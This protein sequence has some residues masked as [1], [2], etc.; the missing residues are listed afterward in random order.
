M[1]VSMIPLSGE[2]KVLDLRNRYLADEVVKL[3]GDWELYWGQIIFPGDLLPP[4]KEIITVPVMWDKD[5]DHPAHGY[6]TYRVS[7]LLPENMPQLAMQ[8][9]FSLNHYQIYIN[10]QLWGANGAIYREPAGSSYSVGPLLRALPGD[11]KLEIIYHVSNFDDLHGGILE[12]PQIG[13]YKKMFKAKERAVIF[14]SFLM[15][16]LFITGM[17][18]ISF[19]M[20]KRDDRSSLF[21]GFFALVMALRTTLYG[22][23]LLLHLF[24]NLSTER[25]AGLGHI[26]LY[27]SRSLFLSFI[28]LSYPFRFSKQL[29][30]AVYGISAAYI[31]LVIFT[32]HSFYI[33]FLLAYQILVLIVGTFS[34]FLLIKKAVGGN[35][36]AIVTLAG[37]IILMGTA[38]N[39]ILYSQELIKTFHMIPLGMAVFI[40]SQ[41][42]L[43]SW[44]I[45]RAFNQ[46]EILAA[47]LLTAN[48]SFRRFVPQE[49]LKF[50]KRERISDVQLGDNV[51]LNMTVLFCDIR[52]FTSLSENMS[53]QENFL[54]LNSFLKRIG[55]VIRE[56]GGFIDKY[57][58]DGIMAL[59]P[60]MPDSAVKAA[61]EMQET[62]K[63][64]NDHRNNSGY[65]NIKI[66]IGINTG[67]LMLGTI[68]EN[69]RMDS[70]VISDAVNLCS[71]IES[72]TKEYGLNIALSEDTYSLLSSKDDLEVRNIGKLTLKGKMKPVTIYEIFNGDQPEMIE[73]KRES[74]EEFEKAV[75]L[76]SMGDYVN[77]LAAF[78][79]LIKIN[80]HDKTLIS[81][82]M[83][84]DRILTDKI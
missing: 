66:G 25:E 36:S 24:N 74:R 4:E 3:E 32:S 33:Q 41:A 16:A 52:D 39:D 58:G 56:N 23:H 34:F 2:D 70:T 62:L 76:F 64:Y 31:L 40:M 65:N 84:L 78:S 11:D 61:L 17:L 54:F 44:N 21:F 15:G 47:E 77:A 71:R 42:S 27:L 14:E 18:Y 13:D 55:P 81:F 46:S 38:V 60:G 28:S 35:N 75:A 48:T 83:K 1:V 37:F 82:Q 22:E 57:I 8:V 72:I 51:Q 80:P 6:G 49:F 26:T 19:Y 43:L 59:F 73:R 63:I 9:P 50:L 12:A 30:T 68:G 69:E 7:V 29:G 79:S 10:G 53:P 5:D 45:G 20:N 67:S